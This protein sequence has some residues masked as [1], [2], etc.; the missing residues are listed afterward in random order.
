MKYRSILHGR[1]WVM[2]TGEQ[3]VVNKK[4]P[5]ISNQF[6]PIHGGAPIT[7]LGERQTL[8]DCKVVGSILTLGG[9]LCP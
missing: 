4:R 5:K 8:V 6:T 9:V 2:F 3:S 7:Q 1:V